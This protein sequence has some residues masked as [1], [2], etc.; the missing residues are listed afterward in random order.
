MFN[1]IFPSKTY[2]VWLISYYADFFHIVHQRVSVSMATVTTDM[3]DA[4]H[5]QMISLVIKAALHYTCLDHLWCFPI[6]MK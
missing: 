6:C 4:K 2:T 5:G 3:T 1:C